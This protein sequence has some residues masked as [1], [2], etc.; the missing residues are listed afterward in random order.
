LN[1][2]KVLRITVLV[3]NTVHQPGLM[4]EHG[5]A[6]WIEADGRRVLFDAGQG[7]ALRHNAQ[8]LRIPLAE[9]DAVALSHGHFDHA[10][11]LTQL[12]RE[13]AGVPIHLHPAALQPRYSKRGSESPRSIGIPDEALQWLQARPNLL[14][15]TTKPVELAPGVWLSGEIPRH[16]SPDSPDGAGHF[17]DEAGIAQGF[18]LDQRCTRPDPVADDQALLIHTTG[19]LVLLL[20]C[21]HSGLENTLAHADRL[22]G[23]VPLRAIIGGMHL[24]RADAPRLERAITA[25][26]ARKP[27]LIAA[28]H[29]TGSRA[30]ALL[31]ERFGRRWAPC[32]VGARFD[33]A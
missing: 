13:M 16:P 1:Q 2:V 18:F 33:F 5:L 12:P 3:E 32:E 19:G 30:V 27:E 7:F 22:R 8:R 25:L 6:F 11:G 23:E 17:Q 4:A 15:P 10:G 24:L 28:G 9:A 21:T 31:R 20:G 29:C 26:A 14:R